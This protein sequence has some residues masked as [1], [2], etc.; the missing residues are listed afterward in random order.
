MKNIKDRMKSK[1]TKP[2]AK[3]DHTLTRVKSGISD[4]KEKKEDFYL[5]M[6]R[7]INN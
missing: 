4:Y 2:L 1:Q 7:G 5:S 6:K 3:E